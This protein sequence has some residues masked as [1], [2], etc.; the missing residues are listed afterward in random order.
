ML[1]RI[2]AMIGALVLT[3]SSR[4]RDRL[5]RQEGQAFVE[6]AIM[7]LIVAVALGVGTALFWKP[8]TDGLTAALNTVKD[9]LSSA[10]G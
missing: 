9:T 3:T 4:V 6:Y 5:E 7:L 8:L 2:S 1:Y 10:P